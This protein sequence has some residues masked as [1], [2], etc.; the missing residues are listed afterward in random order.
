MAGLL[1]LRRLSFKKLSM[2]A[3]A[4]LGDLK[5]LESLWIEETDVADDAL[6]VLGNLTQLKL[7][8]LGDKY[9]TDRDLARLAPL[10][11]LTALRL[12]G[13]SKGPPR[14]R[15]CRIDPS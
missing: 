10:H 9:F 1:E 8:Q 6:Q 2:P 5:Q 15:L 7:L 11:E 12:D 14:Q 3:F 4:G 13:H